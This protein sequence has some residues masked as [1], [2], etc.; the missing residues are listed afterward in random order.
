MFGAPG[1]FG[2]RV[3]PLP[4]LYLEGARMLVLGL[5]AGE[6]VI[7]A[8]GE[9]VVQLVKAGRYQIRLGFQAAPDIRIEREKVAIKRRETEAAQ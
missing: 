5:R 6:R 1:S 8:D 9:V 7:I 2:R 3:P 4:G